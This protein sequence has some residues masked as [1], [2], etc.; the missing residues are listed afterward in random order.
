MQPALGVVVTLSP[1]KDVMARSSG[2]VDEAPVT[3][4][5]SM[6]LYT[7]LVSNSPGLSK[8]VATLTNALPVASDDGTVPVREKVALSPLGRSMPLHW[9]W[10]APRSVHVVPSM[11]A[12]SESA[13]KAPLNVSVTVALGASDGPLLVSVIV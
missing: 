13:A 7:G 5:E 2:P 9:N 12:E 8:T 10:P 3:T 1:L 4:S 11:D 6:A